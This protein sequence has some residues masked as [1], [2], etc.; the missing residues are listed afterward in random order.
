MLADHPLKLPLAFPA[1]QQF[2]YK[3]FIAFPGSSNPHGS[4]PLP[5]MGRHNHAVSVAV[6]LQLILIK[7]GGEKQRRPFPGAVSPVLHHHRQEFFFLTVKGGFHQIQF[8][9]ISALIQF[10][11]KPWGPADSAGIIHTAV[12][13]SGGNINVLLPEHAQFADIPVISCNC[14]EIVHQPAVFQPFLL[15]RHGFQLSQGL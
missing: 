8:I 2:R 11:C 10:P 5:L 7:L 9:G 4:D 3:F 6:L 14:T 15:L 13:V 12:G 1:L